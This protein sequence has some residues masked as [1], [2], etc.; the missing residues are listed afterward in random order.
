VPR[1]QPPKI[2]SERAWTEVARVSTFGSSTIALHR[3][4][5]RTKLRL[6]PSEVVN[7]CLTSP[8]YWAARDYEAKDQIGLEPLV[9]DYIDGIVEVFRE[10]HR[11]LTPDGTAWLNLG[12]CYIHSPEKKASAPRANWM[13]N[14]QLSLIP[15]RVALRLQE[16]GWWVRN[17]VVWHKPNAMPASVRDRLTGAWEPVFLLTKAEQYYFDLDAIREPHKTDDTVEHERARRGTANGKA[18]GQEELRRWL[19]S[20]RHRAT[21]E[22][23]REVRR[24]PNSP[25][26]VELAAYLKRAVQAQ[27][28]GIKWVAEQLDEPF[29]RVRHYFRTDRIGSRLPPEPTWESLKS[30]LNLG[31]EF[32]DVMAVEVGDNL[33]R[34]HRNGRNPGDVR[35]IPVTRAS[36]SHF[37]AMPSRLAEWALRATLPAG[38]VCLDPFMGIGTTGLAAIKLGGRFI[39]IDVRRDFLREFKNNAVAITRSENSREVAPLLHL[40]SAR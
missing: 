28:V 39:G 3:G 7:T 34:N 13:R 38:G 33:F 23:L 26:P 21:I 5:A 15:F 9:D 16:E 18:K 24:R 30:L 31:T 17:V 40:A 6:L 27:G 4:D 8:P 29:E 12:D 11:V 10:V 20:P 25:D 22:G 32:D 19:N 37:A 14:K 35:V 1:N 2:M 36:E